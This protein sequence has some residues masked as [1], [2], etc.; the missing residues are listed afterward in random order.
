[1]VA[2]FILTTGTIG[3]FSL[4]R[5][6]LTF[7]NVTSSQLTAAYLAQEGIE[8]VRNIRD[9]NWLEVRTNPG[10]AWDDG[11]SGSGNPDF[12]LDYQSSSFPDNNCH[13]GI[14]NY[15]KYD[16]TYF[17]CLT[18]NNTIFQRKIT[19]TKSDPNV[20]NVLVEV[21]FTIKGGTHKVIVQENLYK[22]H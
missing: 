10:L 4:I 15:L 8:I 9:S 5:N 18:G 16:G 11:I 6:T 3:A 2:I 20:L 19:I 12:R 1:M 17:N 13:L 21:S 7:T 22:W 14:D